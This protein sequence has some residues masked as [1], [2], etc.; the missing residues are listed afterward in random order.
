MEKL[1]LE[2]DTSSEVIESSDPDV[3][4]IWIDTDG[5]VKVETDDKLVSYPRERVERYE[6]HI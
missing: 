2:S 4:K 6:Q 1:V 3:K 5:W